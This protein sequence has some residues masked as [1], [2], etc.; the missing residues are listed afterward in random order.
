MLKQY[1][2]ESKIEV[3]I[4]EAGRGCLFGPVCVAAVIWPH[5]DPEPCLEIKDSKKVS[6]KKRYLLKDYIEQNA[7]AYSVQFVSHEE[8]DQTNILQATMK[9]MHLCIDDIRKN[10]TIDTLLIDGNHF[11][12]YTDE[13][14]E[15]ID[16]ECVISGDNTYKSI[17]AASILAKTYRD[18][19]I[20]QLVKDRPELDS[21]ALHKNKGYGTKIHMV[22]LKQYGPVEGHRRSFKPCH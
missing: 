12:I 10:H 15:Y 13:N 11:K 5:E 19:Y 6:E 16:H 14:L 8:I 21:Y 4:D 2:D 18:N 9:G 17:A 3:G 7:L 20:Y 22:A 1:L